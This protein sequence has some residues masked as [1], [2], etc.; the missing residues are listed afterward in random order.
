M[1]STTCL[2]LILLTRKEKKSSFI[3]A[4]SLKSKVRDRKAAFVSG[5]ENVR[6]LLGKAD[7]NL[8]QDIDE[9]LE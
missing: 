4:L 9:V 1:K 7:L 8:S 3:W 6:V 5:E 2:A